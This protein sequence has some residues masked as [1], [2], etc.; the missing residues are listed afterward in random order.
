M[1][2]T[3]VAR[4]A[5]LSLLALLT[6]AATHAQSAFDNETAASGVPAKPSFA[7]ARVRSKVQPGDDLG[8]VHTGMFCGSDAVTHAV[9]QIEQATN[10]SVKAAFKIAAREADLP[11][12][13]PE[14][15]PFE[16]A[17][18]R[19]A[20][21]LLGGVLQR[22]T[23]DVC[24]DGP[25]RKGGVEVEMKWELFST[26]LQRVVL[27][28][29]TSGGFKTDDYV[30]FNLDPKAYQQAL[31]ALLQSPE[32]KALAAGRLP[33]GAGTPTWQPLH[34]QPG[35]A[36]DGDAQGHADALTKAV[37]TIVSDLGSGT[38]FYIADGYLLTDRH[39]V[40]SSKYV[41]VKLANGRQLV[42]E[43]IRQDASRDVALLQTE[44]AGVPS[45]RVSLADPP[46]GAT[47]FAIGSPLGETLA[48]TFTRG[49]LSGVRDVNGTRL[50]QSDVAINHG[51]SGGP[52]LDAGSH[53]VGLA[54][55][56]IAQTTGLSFFV[57]IKDALDRLNVVIDGGATGR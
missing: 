48:G 17:A 29:T 22:I 7:F 37:V 28:K 27:T 43:V 26:K 51:N 32:F 6:A 56:T 14:L 35:T 11:V 50:L 9:A 4:A 23:Y 52:L 24:V 16:T 30:T 57:P 15:S 46:V 25:R 49:V 21:Y 12:F 55:L 19:S 41:K 10:N 42:G 38:G 1:H 20:D 34:L 2:G 54:E 36:I 45:L 3:R 33:E 8:H 44:S 18:P 5:I 53:V 40:G 31:Q 47:T 13:E 39:V